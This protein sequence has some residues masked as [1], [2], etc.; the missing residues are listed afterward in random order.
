MDTIIYIGCMIRLTDLILHGNSRPTVF[1]KSLI[2]LGGHPSNARQH[3][4]Q[5]PDD[6]RRSSCPPQPLHSTAF[7]VLFDSKD[8][9]TALVGDQPR[10]VFLGVHRVCDDNPAGGV[11][12]L[13]QRWE[14]DDFVRLVQGAR[15]TCV[16]LSVVE[17]R[18]ERGAAKSAPYGGSLPIRSH[19]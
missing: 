3:W 7:V 11:E 15:D 8:E 10:L 18:F 1:K 14:G 6:R 17:V 9:V 5:T 4:S 2:Q 13:D 19:G 16:G 12:W